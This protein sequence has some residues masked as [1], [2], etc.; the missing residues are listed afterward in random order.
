MHGDLFSGS[1]AAPSSWV[2]LDVCSAAGSFPQGPLPAWC[3]Q[4]GI[5]SQK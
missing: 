5:Q 3:A 4:G 1:G 2:H